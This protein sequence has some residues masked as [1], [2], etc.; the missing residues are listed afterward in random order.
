MPGKT[1]TVFRHQLLQTVLSRRYLYTF[2]AGPLL[3]MAGIV[4]AASA[5]SGVIAPA[6]K[7]VLSVAVGYVD[8]AGLMGSPPKLLRRFETAEAASAAL[9]RRELGAYFVVPEDVAQGGTV[10]VYRPRMAFFVLDRP[11]REAVRHA[12]LHD[13]DADVRWRLLRPV[14]LTTDTVAVPD[15]RVRSLGVS[16]F[17][18]VVCVALWVSISFLLEAFAT[19]RKNRLYELLL[20]SVPLGRL[21][22]GK[23]LALGLA[24]LFPVAFWG[25]FVALLASPLLLLL[26]G[27]E[28]DLTVGL[29]DAAILVAYFLLG[30][31]AF[32]TLCVGLSATTRDPGSAKAVLGVGIWGVLLVSGFVDADFAESTL[33]LV[34]AAVPPMSIF[35][36]PFHLSY[37]TVPGWLVA[38]SLTALAAFDALLFLLA[39]KL[40]RAD[41]LL[42]GQGYSARALLRALR[43]A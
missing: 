36:V 40:V 39:R 13:V 26:F 34:L 3:L 24:G 8:P 16:L 18:V 35:M 27:A 29:L 10:Q 15:A 38:T 28:K 25:S 31:V 22:I 19:E 42:Y 17:G 37:G 5:F 2:L 9:R 6:V 32:A 1:Y 12:L 30:Y 7:G 4:V 41:Q 21:L 20:A 11:I 33:G 23:A 14:D 43:Q